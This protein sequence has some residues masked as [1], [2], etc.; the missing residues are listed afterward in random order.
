MGLAT[1]RIADRVNR[2]EFRKLLTEC[3]PLPGA[4]MDTD[5]I[6]NG[7]CHPEGYVVR[8]K[9][10]ELSLAS[11]VFL[12]HEWGYDDENRS[13]HETV[14]TINKALRRAG[15]VTWF[16]EDQEKQYSTGGKF[17][18]AGASAKYDAKEHNKALKAAAAAAP[19]S[20]EHTSFQ[21]AYAAPVVEKKGVS[22]VCIYIYMGICMCGCV[23]M[24]V[25][26]VNACMRVSSLQVYRS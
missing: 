20:S 6:F 8:D 7:I 24:F 21:P 1:S 10:L 17:A 13:V 3:N 23:Y 11:D 15:V 22:V 25:Y 19:K 12:S 2:E 4:A 9:I 26:C 16:D 5:T 14:G 18:A